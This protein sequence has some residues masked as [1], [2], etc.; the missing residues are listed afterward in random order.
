MTEVGNLETAKRDWEDLFSNR[1][2]LQLMRAVQAQADTLQQAI[3]FEPVEN[4]ASLYMLE[5][6]KGKLEG[7][8]SL[9]ATA[10][11]MQDEVLTDLNAARNRKGTDNVEN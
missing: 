5:R 11:A 2:W 8:L 10:L 3:L 9:A 4:E 1:A 7:R 6:K